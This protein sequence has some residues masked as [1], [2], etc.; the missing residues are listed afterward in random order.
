[1]LHLRYS[2]WFWMHLCRKKNSNYHLRHCLKYT[3]ISPNL[4]VWEFC[5]KAQFPQSFWRFAQNFSETVPFHKISTPGNYVKLRYFT[6]WYSGHAIFRWRFLN[7]FLM[8]FI[9]LGVI[10]RKKTKQRE[11]NKIHL[12]LESWEIGNS[13]R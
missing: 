5:G 2:A 4:L 11:S 6:Q 7:P 10:M 8:K 1:M 3:I 13:C 12:A 9:I